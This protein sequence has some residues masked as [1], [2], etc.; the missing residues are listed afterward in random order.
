MFIHCGGLEKLL[1]MQIAYDE[2][3]EI[4]DLVTNII[5]TYDLTTRIKI[6]AAAA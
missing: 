1:G 3:E 6:I 5:E 4:Y 2:Y